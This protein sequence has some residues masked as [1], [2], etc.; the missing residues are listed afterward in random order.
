MIALAPLSAT[1]AG[2]PEEGAQYLPAEYFP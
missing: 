2:R 1:A